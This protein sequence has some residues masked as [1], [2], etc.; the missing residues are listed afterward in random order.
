MESLPYEQRVEIFRRLPRHSLFAVSQVSRA[1]LDAASDERLWVDDGFRDD[2][3]R[4]GHDTSSDTVSHVGNTPTASGTNRGVLNNL[5]TTNLNATSNLAPVGEYASGNNTLILTAVSQW[6]AHVLRFS[7][8]AIYPMLSIEKNSGFHVRVSLH[9]LKTHLAAAETL[10]GDEKSRDEYVRLDTHSKGRMSGEQNTFESTTVHAALVAIG[11]FTEI[12]ER[13]AEKLCDDAEFARRALRKP[14]TSLQCASED[15]AGSPS[16]TSR[17]AYDCINT[18]ATAAAAEAIRPERGCLRIR[19][20][21]AFLVGAY[22]RTIPGRTVRDNTHRSRNMFGK[23]RETQTPP[24]SRVLPSDMTNTFGLMSIGSSDKTHIGTSNRKTDNKKPL[25]VRPPQPQTPWSTLR[26]RVVG[27]SL[28]ATHRETVS[29]TKLSSTSPTTPTPLGWGHSTHVVFDASRGGASLDV[30]DDGSE[31]QS[32]P[33]AGVA[34]PALVRDP[35]DDAGDNNEFPDSGS[36][37]THDPAGRG[38]QR[39]F[40]VGGCGCRDKVS[41]IVNETLSVSDITSFFDERGEE[42]EA[43]ERDAPSTR[44][45]DSTERAAA[46]ALALLAFAPRAH[47]CSLGGGRFSRLLGRS[48]SA[49]RLARALAPR[50]ERFGLRS[51]LVDEEDVPSSDTTDSFSKYTTAT[52]SDA[53]LALQLERCEIAMSDSIDKWEPQCA[54]EAAI[55]LA[56]A[57]AIVARMEMNRSR[58]NAPPASPGG[59]AGAGAGGLDDTDGTRKD[60]HAAR[61]VLL[62]RTRRVLDRL[63]I[64]VG[65]L[66]NERI[67]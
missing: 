31:T 66:E 65:V 64:S 5:S 32:D 20:S 16:T 62:E 23:P 63:L 57:A 38:R 49:I 22:G 54:A 61:Q 47:E 45:L 30:A 42:S 17:R 25:L 2:M 19:L 11:E 59:G 10:F 28:I 36:T 9:P 26:A 29:A 15:T 48:V 4:G 50:R 43:T 14:V 35:R 3:N 60:L 24:W 41:V 52:E 13:L 51:L 44:P 58:L 67:M 12:A 39:G 56:T 6:I 53:S 37:T 18:A 21:R 27:E 1:M 33:R 55:D 8:Y 40:I 46:T 34:W 7:P